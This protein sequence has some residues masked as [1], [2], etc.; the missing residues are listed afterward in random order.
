MSDTVRSERAA[1]GAAGVLVAGST[2]VGPPRTL[3]L[4]RVLAFSAGLIGEPGWPQ[5]NLHTNTDIALE[6]GLPA[7]IASGTQF[8]GHLVDFL[9][10]LF[11]VA[12]LS[13][14][15]LVIRIPR[16]AHVGDTVRPVVRVTS[17][18]GD[19]G[20]RV[21]ELEVAMENQRGEHVLSG[22]ATYREPDAG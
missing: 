16:S 1:I 4:P 11:G 19:A 21:V 22:T 8:E 7:I 18:A 15:E 9:I 14:G 3:T 10:T 17:I 2:H 6:A 5:Q 12:W 13:A 20:A